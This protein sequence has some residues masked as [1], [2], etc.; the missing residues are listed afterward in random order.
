MRVLIW[1]PSSL[2]PLPLTPFL[3]PILFLTT[4][5]SH[6]INCDLYNT[7]SLNGDIAK[8]L[9]MRTPTT[10]DLK[11]A[12]NQSF[13][14]LY[15]GTGFFKFSIP[16]VFFYSFL[17]YYILSNNLQVYLLN[18]IGRE[19]EEVYS[20]Y[21]FFSFPANAKLFAIL[22]IFVNPIIGDPFTL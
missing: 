13:D 22:S 19:S 4:T 8:V 21:L 16:C 11:R 14:E 2:I 9:L 15:C 5:S 10:Y 6:L 20:I 12:W 18:L 1:F 3:D 17:F 7:I